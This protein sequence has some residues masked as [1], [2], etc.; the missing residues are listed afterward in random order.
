MFFL[1]GES[2]SGLT[3]V[4]HSP[5]RFKAREKRFFHKVIVTFSITVVVICWIVRTRVSWVLVRILFLASDQVLGHIS[6]I[7]HTDVT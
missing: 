4:I 1:H 5:E 6:L 2:I 7:L 3:D